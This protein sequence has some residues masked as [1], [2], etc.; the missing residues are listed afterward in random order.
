MNAVGPAGAA[1]HAVSGH[2]SPYLQTAVRLFRELFPEYERYV[3]FLE[4]CAEC[5][6]PRYPATHNHLWVLERGNAAIGLRVFCYLPRRDLGY[7]IFIGVL[8]PYRSLGLG[9][10]LVRQ[11]IDQLASDAKVYRR[12]EPLGYCAEVERVGDAESAADRLTRQR[13][14]AFHIRNGALLLPVDYL[15][16]PMPPGENTVA[17]T[18]GHQ[19]RPMHFNPMVYS[20]IKMVLML[21][22]AHLG[23]A[24]TTVS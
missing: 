21:P 11:T 17:S 9:A 22:S 18:S 13:R 24:Y 7:G 4:A 5:R 14:L 15:E 6:S 2:D 12:P 8:P 10:W 3:P 23:Q 19:P 20:V 16:P 1:I